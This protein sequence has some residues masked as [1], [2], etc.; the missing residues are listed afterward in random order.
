VGR[1]CVSIRGKGRD[2]TRRSWDDPF[3]ADCSNTGGEETGA[4]GFS[5]SLSGQLDDGISGLVDKKSLLRWEFEIIIGR[6]GLRLKRQKTRR[7]SN[8]RAAT[9]P[10]T[11]PARVLDEMRFELFELS[12]KFVRVG[13][14]DE[15][16]FGGCV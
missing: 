13:P 8:T 16:D 15:S 14:V 2:G 6:F 3:G 10:T 12:G 11:I 7:A 4:S 1:T 9:P 5:E